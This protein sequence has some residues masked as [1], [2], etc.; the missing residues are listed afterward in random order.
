M[1]IAIYIIYVHDDVDVSAY[2]YVNVYA[3]GYANVLVNRYMYVYIDI[4]ICT[5][6]KMKTDFRD[7]KYMWKSKF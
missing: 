1:R 3:D 2:E 6:W 4:Y 7:C 5:S